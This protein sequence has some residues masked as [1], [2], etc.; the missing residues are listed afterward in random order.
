MDTSKKI[1]LF[2][3]PKKTP[4]LYTQCCN[5]HFGMTNLGI[6]FND[7]KMILDDA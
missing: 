1:N 6:F 3:Q 7:L 4:L 5:N 2:I